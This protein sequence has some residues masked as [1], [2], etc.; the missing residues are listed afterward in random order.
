M[1]LLTVAWVVR[2]R[3]VMVR[4]DMNFSSLHGN[5]LASQ[6]TLGTMDQEEWVSR[7]YIQKTNVSW[8]MTACC[9]I[10]II[11]FCLLRWVTTKEKHFSVANFVHQVYAAFSSNSSYEIYSL[12]SSLHPLS[13]L[14]H[15][16]FFTNEFNP[17]IIK[18]L[19]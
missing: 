13:W 9:F 17:L 7:P 2:C 19:N 3:V 10:I 11:F 16:H 18:V 5:A 14:V 4:F 8:L 12:S 6:I 1:L 15:L